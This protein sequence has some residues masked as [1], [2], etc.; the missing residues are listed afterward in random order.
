MSLDAAELTREGLAPP[1]RRTEFLR[2]LSGARLPALF[3]VLVA[4]T[5]IA[6]PLLTSYAPDAG[7]PDALQ[8]PLSPGHW[9]GT[10]N[11]GRDLWAE[12]AYG[13]RVSLSVGILAAL[14][15]LAIGVVV[16]AAAGYAGGALDAF[17]MRLSEFFQTLPRFVLALIIVALF[18]AGIGKVILVLAILSWPQ[19]ARVVRA[20]VMSLKTAPFIDAARVG[21]MPPTAIVLREILPNAL[22]PIVVVTSLDVATA[23]LLEA[24]LSFFGLGDPNL[25]SWGAMLNV[26]QDYLRQAW[27]MSLF[28]GAAIALTV[29]AFNRIGD[30][31]NDAL[32]PKLR[33]GR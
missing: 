30:C 26:A 21:G 15:A 11:I 29:L 33:D 3:V 20:S 22:A 16:G 31:L 14:S 7:G 9:L 2:R 10:D 32:N 23:I 12:L 25:P 27:W 13:A 19:T 18:G 5:A 24:S 17:L 28:P 4:A 8:P 6:A 1:S